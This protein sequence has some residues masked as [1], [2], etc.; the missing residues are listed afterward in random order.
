MLHSKPC[1]RD[2]CSAL[3]IAASP[4]ELRRRRYHSNACRAQ[5]VRERGDQGDCIFSDA[6]LADALAEMRRVEQ[7]EQR[8]RLRQREDVRCPDNDVEQ[9]R[10]RDLQL[11]MIAEYLA[12]QRVFAS[13]VLPSRWRSVRCTDCPSMIVARPHSSAVPSLQPRCVPCTERFRRTAFEA[14]S[15]KQTL[16][17]KTRKARHAA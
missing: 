16:L 13:E 7:A 5:A 2:G 6:D 15:A 8:E 3:V 1:S 4:S 14:R 9:R 10:I 12:A 11:Q 17:A